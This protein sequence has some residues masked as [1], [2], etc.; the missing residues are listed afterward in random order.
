MMKAGD[1]K[2]VDGTEI[3]ND[4]SVTYVRDILKGIEDAHINLY[5]H[6]EKAL[7]R[8]AARKFESWGFADADDLAPEAVNDAFY[9]ALKYLKNFDSDKGPFIAWMYAITNTACADTARKQGRHRGNASL[10]QL[11]D[12]GFDF[13]SSEPLIEEQVAADDHINRLFGQMPSQYRDVPRAIWLNGSTQRE[14]AKRLGKG[15]GPIGKQMSRAKKLFFEI[16][17]NER[18]EDGNDR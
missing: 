18:L 12:D 15:R 10:E 2:R 4:L 17:Q 5:A 3:N 14:V 7:I 8:R 16:F 13:Q 11:L 6:V 1:E 9:N